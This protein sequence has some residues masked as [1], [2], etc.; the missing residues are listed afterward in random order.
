M[1][2]QAYLDTIKAKTGKGLE[3]FKAL[4]ASRGL[5]GPGAKAG[6]VLAWLKQDFELGH[7]H[8]MAIYAI[9]KSGDGPRASADERM[10]RLFSG[11]KAPRRAEF[12]AVLRKAREFGDDVG[13]APTDTYVSL[14]RGARKFAIVQPSAR[15]LD[16]GLKRS[17]VAPT[18]RFAGAGAW[19]SMVT[20]RV[21]IDGG[22]ELEAD[23]LNW[24]RLAYDEVRWRSSASDLSR[25]RSPVRLSPNNDR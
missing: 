4:A 14:L 10:A 3:D 21:R 19:N 25:V 6:E 12:D 5:M 18:E 16:L 1:S 13:F 22:V 24:L 17:G 11:A 8:A 23:V 9:L 15:H 20:H 2:F 7:G